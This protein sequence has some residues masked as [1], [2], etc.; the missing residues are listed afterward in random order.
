M[1][2]KLGVWYWLLTKRLFKKWSFWLLL[3]AVP[4]LVLG[5]RGI[6]AQKAS[7]LTMVFFAEPSED[8]LGAEIARQLEASDGL[9][10]YERCTSEE[11]LR[12][13]VAYG[14]AD[15]GYV[16][17][18]ELSALVREYVDGKRQALPYDG[19]LILFVARE[20]NIALKLAREQFFSVIFPSISEMLT[21][22]FTLKQEEFASMDETQASQRLKT[23]YDELSVDDSIFEFALGSSGETERLS[24][25]NYLTAP[26]RGLLAVFVLACGLTMALYLIRDRRDGLL[27]QLPVHL[28][29]VIS[30]IYIFSGTLVC[31]AAAFAGLVFSGTFTSWPGE[32]LRMVLLI[33]AVTAFSWLVSSIFENIKAPCRSDAAGDFSIACAVPGICGI[34][35]AQCGKILPAAVLLSYRTL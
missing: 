25:T 28:R 31:G 6:A 26:L 30:W 11:Q 8:G 10:C 12:D 13:R 29:P 18:A 15:G 4:L 32:C 1:M 2:R 24:Q 33:L 5:M 21:E 35:R 9:I 27:A 34:S 23:L 17:P 19:H 3:L 22:S 16:I 14:K 7:V 20:D